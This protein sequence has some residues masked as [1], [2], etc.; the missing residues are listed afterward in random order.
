MKN[1]ILIIILVLTVNFS[2]AQDDGFQEDYFRE[3][4][5]V[6][7]IENYTACELFWSEKGISE[8]NG[9]T[10]IWSICN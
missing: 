5:N 6:E 10:E 3:E 4:V 2:F 1:S 8:F 9:K 7:L